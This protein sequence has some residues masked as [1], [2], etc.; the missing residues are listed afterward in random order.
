M[1][2][3]RTQKLGTRH[4]KNYTLNKNMHIQYLSGLNLSWVIG[5]GTNV[6]KNRNDIG[7]LCL[8]SQLCVM[9]EHHIIHGVK[10]FYS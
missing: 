8:Y 2:Q 1:C 10:H 5:K 7:K 4:H 3:K 6:M 9:Y